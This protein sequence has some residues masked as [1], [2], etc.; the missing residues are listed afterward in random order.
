MSEQ[1]TWRRDRASG[2]PLGRRPARSAR[3]ALS[4]VGASLRGG[5]G[6]VSW[7]TRIRR[8]RWPAV[9]LL[10]VTGALVWLALASPWLRVTS[11]NVLG[12]DAQ[13]QA[14]VRQTAL[15]E[16]GKPLVK[17]DSAALQRDLSAVP[18]FARV[19]VIRDWPDRLTIVVVVRTPVMAVRKSVGP[20]QL[21]D[22]EGV[23]YASVDAPPQGV[24]AVTLAHADVDREIRAAAG[25]LASLD[26]GQRARVSSATVASPDD[27]RFVIDDVT[28]IWGGHSEG[29]RK[30]VTM[31]ALLQQKGIRTVNVSAPDSPVIS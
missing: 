20:L 2:A 4:L 25:V 8:L 17:V 30:A 31:A 9:A 3:P 14:L 27:V 21:V 23:G 5:P 28:V 16:E 26:P 29:R 15:R 19:D 18:A 6:R 13:Q 11:I 10:A 22:A 7:G 1:E 12:G 24:P